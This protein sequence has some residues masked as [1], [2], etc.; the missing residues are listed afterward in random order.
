MARTIVGLNDAKAVKKYSAFLASDS[1]RDSYFSS[2]FMGKGSDSMTPIQML[3]E[4]ESDA[5]EEIKFDLSIQL[6]QQPTEGD[7]ILEGNEESLTFYTDSVYIDQSR[8]GVNAGGRMT[9]KRTVHDLRPIARKRLSEYWSRVFDENFMIYGAGARGVNSDFVYPTSW[10]GRAN[11]SLA[12]P[13][14]DHLM[15]GGNATA[16]NNVDSSDIM[17]LTVIE[18]AVTKAKTLGGG[19][20]GIPRVQPIKVNGRKGYVLVMHE[21]QAYDL[22]TTTTTG[23]WLDIQKAAAGADG[24][25]NPMFRDSLG[26]YR[27]VILHSH[28]AIVRFSDYGSGVN[29]PAARALFLGQQALVCA[30]GSPGNNL[31]FGWYEDTDDR[32]NQLIVDTDTIWGCKKVRFNS[33][34]FGLIAIDTYAIDPNA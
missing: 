1:A 6:K 12:A 14:S 30:F 34:D 15:Y 10:T 26:M 22:R 17:S 9:R 19:T 23:Q 5:G 2:R 4:L 7:D 13:D 11:N 3:A 24:Q 31:R 25:K 16:K 21:F 32:G 33:K 18:K 20:E 28:E 27:D 29:L 8:H